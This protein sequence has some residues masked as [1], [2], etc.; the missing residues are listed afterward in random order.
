MVVHQFLVVVAI[1]V[2]VSVVF[3]VRTDVVGGV[4]YVWHYCVRRCLPGIWFV[5]NDDLITYVGTI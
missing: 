2:S 3:D 1:V 4:F 5:F